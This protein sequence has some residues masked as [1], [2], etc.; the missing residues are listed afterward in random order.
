[1][2]AIEF[3]KFSCSSKRYT[4]TLSLYITVH[5][6]LKEKGIYKTTKNTSLKSTEEIYGDF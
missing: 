5:Q 4:D 2:N 3:F 1:M 6:I